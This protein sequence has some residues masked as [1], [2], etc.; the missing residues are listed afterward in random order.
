MPTNGDDKLVH[1]DNCEDKIFVISNNE[2]FHSKWCDKYLQNGMTTLHYS[3]TALKELIASLE[4]VENIAQMDNFSKVILQQYWNADIDNVHLFA[5]TE[6]PQIMAKVAAICTK[7][8]DESPVVL[9]ALSGMT[10]DE[11]TEKHPSLR[12]N[13]SSSQQE[14]KSWAVK[15]VTEKEEGYT[16]LKPVEAVGLDNV[17][18]VTTVSEDL[19][20]KSSSVVT[21]NKTFALTSLSEKKKKNMDEYCHITCQEVIEHSKLNSSND[22]IQIH[23]VISVPTN[24]C[25]QLQNQSREGVMEDA[26]SVHSQIELSLALSENKVQQPSVL[27][28]REDK[29]EHSHTILKVPQYEDISDDEDKSQFLTNLPNTEHEELRFPPCIEEFQYEDISNDENPQIETSLIQVSEP[30]NKQPPSENEDC[31]HVQDQAQN[32][33]DERLAPKKKVLPKTGTLDISQDCSC[34][35]FGETDGF[36]RLFPEYHS[37]RHLE[38]QTN[39]SDSPSSVFKDGDETDDQM[40]DDWIVIP[41]NMTDLTYETEDE[42][43]DVRENVVLDDGETGDKERQGDT[44]PTHSEF[45]CPAPNPVPASS[46]SHIEV[47]DTVQSFLQAKAGR[48]F[49]VVSAKNTPEHDKDCEPHTP[50]N[51]RE[52]YSDSE[53]SC[54]TED[55]CDY[56]SASEHNYLTVSRQLLKERSVSQMHDS[57]SEKDCEHDEAT[58]VQEGQT[59]SLDKLSHMQKLRQLIEAKVD[60]KRAQPKANKQNTSKKENEDIIII[61]DSDTEDESDLKCEK[62]SKR[63]AFSSHSV[64]CRD[65][66]WDQQRGHPPET[67]D[68]QCG[69]LKQKFKKNRWPSEGSPAPQCQSKLHQT[70]VKEVI[71][72]S[73]SDLTV[74][75]KKSGQLIKTK[76]GSEHFQQKKS[77]QTTSKRRF[78]CPDSDKVVKE[79]TRSSVSK[80]SGSALFAIQNK[81]STETVNSLCGTAEGEPQKTFALL[82]E[83]SPERRPRSVYKEAE[84]NLGPNPV[85]HRLFVKKSSQPS[86]YL[87]FLKESEV[88]SQGKNEALA[89]KTPKATSKKANS[90]DK[91]TLHLHRDEQGRFVSKPEPAND[92][93]SARKNKVQA[94]VT[95]PK[96]VARQLSLPSQEGSSISTSSLTSTSGQLSEARQSST[97]SRGLPQSGNTTAFSGLS[98]TM[99]CTPVPRQRLSSS[100]LKRSHSYSSPSTSDHPHTPTKVPSP[101]TTMQPSATKR[102]TNDW[103][104]SYFP[105]RWDRKIGMGMGIEEALRTTNYESKEGS[106]AR[107]QART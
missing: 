26:G 30:N 24:Q 27:P 18:G 21:G 50:Q 15:Q 89:P 70:Q 60:S 53:D 4:K 33:S 97:S 5:S 22:K 9:N 90:C 107:V 67:V 43:Q 66:S 20:T 96:P 38:W 54:E 17:R 55:S 56:S 40:D 78:V 61:H 105:T 19:Q 100:K 81:T 64:N 103:Q 49:E 62:K 74:S 45:H 14:Y 8:E 86:N 7:N 31:E 3:L 59:Q 92:R 2:S 102:V 104:K 85:I 11:L 65:A 41:V 87:K 42:D 106:N 39:L 93:L 37:E 44:N 84:S 63:K 13:C 58:N 101:R 79:R 71:Q 83:D 25:E 80:D 10:L 77:R 75:I 29:E 68:S 94:S 82:L 91:K 46:S 73:C 34:P 32:I 57:V 28:E 76:S 69:T 16:G 48:S 23:N 88:H 99:Q 35:C 52:S 95:R 98:K 36:E 6:Y 51:R 47:F 72:D 1:S 12:P